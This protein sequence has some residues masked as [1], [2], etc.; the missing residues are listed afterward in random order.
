[1]STAFWNSLLGN[2]D[3]NKANGAKLMES[4][5]K[6]LFDRIPIPCIIAQSLVF[7]TSSLSSFSFS[8]KG[9]QL[10]SVVIDILLQNIHSV[11]LKKRFLPLP[12]KI[13]DKSVVGQGY[14]VQTCFYP[15]FKLNQQ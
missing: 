10:G 4:S 1:M 6:A 15:L 5:E 7:E 14:A 2:V 3:G 12:F 13:T 9:T 8:G 11:T